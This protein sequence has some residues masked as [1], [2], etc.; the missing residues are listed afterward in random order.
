MELFKKK[1]A[2]EVIKA[3]VEAYN[4]ALKAA[5]IAFDEA[6]DKVA[7]AQAAKQDAADQNDAAAFAA[8]KKQLS[9]AETALEMATMRKNRLVEKGAVPPEEV[10]AAKRGYDQQIREI[11]ARACKEIVDRLTALNDIVDA[12]NAEAK[13]VYFKKKQICDLLG[14]EFDS[15]MGSPVNGDYIAAKAFQRAWPTNTM[16]RTN[17]NLQRFAAQVKS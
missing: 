4:A 14:I 11:N 6:E 17:A 5:E 8:A 16:I 12:A 13:A 1:D 2:L 3:K 15:F 9:D 10:A 7:T